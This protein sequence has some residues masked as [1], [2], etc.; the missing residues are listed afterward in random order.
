MPA[1]FSG[2]CHA[3]FIVALLFGVWRRRGVF[4]PW[5]WQHLLWGKH[6][7][8]G[9]VTD[10]QKASKG[11]RKEPQH[12]SYRSNLP[13]IEVWLIKYIIGGRFEIRFSV[14]P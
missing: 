2:E 7:A 8:K 10:H 6:P 3:V 14:Y 13:D 12:R 5:S 9:L 1:T 11:G 4:S